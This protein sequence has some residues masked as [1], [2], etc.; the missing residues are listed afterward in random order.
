MKIGNHERKIPVCIGLSASVSYER[1]DKYSVQNWCNCTRRLELY[2]LI[3]YL[4]PWHEYQEFIVT[5]W[6]D[7]Y[8]NQ[9]YDWW[10]VDDGILISPIHSRVDIGPEDYYGTYQFIGLFTMSSKLKVSENLWRWMYFQS[11]IA[12]VSKGFCQRRYESPSNCAKFS[13][14]VR[15][16]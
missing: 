2:Q 11:N 9:F 3:I 4:F 10:D 16:R 1:Q 14:A 7:G 5:S 15:I 13:V 12:L 8:S 6:F